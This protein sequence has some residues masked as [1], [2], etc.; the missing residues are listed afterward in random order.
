LGGRVSSVTQSALFDV[1]PF[2]VSG[3][4]RP[5]GLEELELDGITYLLVDFAEGDWF[6][7]MGWYYG[8]PPCCVEHFGATMRRRIERSEAAVHHAVSGHVLCPACAAGPSAPLPDR[9]ARRY[10]RLRWDVDEGRPLF[11]PPSDY[12]WRFA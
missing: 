9:P 2:T 6:A 11:Y 5:R 4:P 12:N 7:V 8:Y 3:L 10:G 1:K